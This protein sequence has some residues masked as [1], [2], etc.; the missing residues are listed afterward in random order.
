MQVLVT[1]MFK[2]KNGIAPKLT[3][4]PCGKWFGF[5]KLAKLATLF[6]TESLSYLGPK[7]WDLLPQDLKILTSL[8]NAIQISSKKDGFHKTALAESA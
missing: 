2:V 3:F 1:E 6:G 4:K 5:G 7:L 8:A